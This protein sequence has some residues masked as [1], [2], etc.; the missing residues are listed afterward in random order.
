MCQFLIFHLNYDFEG[1]SIEFEIWNYQ[2]DS[3]RPLLCGDQ[4]S[5]FYLNYDFEGFSIEFEIWNY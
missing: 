5:S 4:F 2:N 3:W 1:F